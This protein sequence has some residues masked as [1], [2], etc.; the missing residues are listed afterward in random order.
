MYWQSRFRFKLIR[1]ILTG[2]P[3]CRQLADSQCAAQHMHRPAAAPSSV[4]RNYSRVRTG[5][6][7]ANIADFAQARPTQPLRTKHTTLAVIH[8]DAESKQGRDAV[9]W[10]EGVV[11]HPCAMYATS[12]TV[13]AMCKSRPPRIT[14]EESPLAASWLEPSTYECDARGQEQSAEFLR[15]AWEVW[16]FM[17]HHPTAPRHG[18]ED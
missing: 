3:A 18:G 5:E 12:A 11:L 4:L 9:F 17:W 15:L 1:R 2:S 8:A 16:P 6:A 14:L 10:L 7:S 13:E